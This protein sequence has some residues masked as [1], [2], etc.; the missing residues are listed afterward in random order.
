M[1]C[2]QQQQHTFVDIINGEKQRRK[3]SVDKTFWGDYLE[4]GKFEGKSAIKKILGKHN[5]ENIVFAD[6]VLKINKR[7]KMQQR[8]LICTENAL[9]NIDPSNYKLKRRIPYKSLGM[10]SLSQ[11]P[12]NFFLFHVPDEYDYLM[13]SGKKVEIVTRVSAEYEKV[14]GK[15]L[16]IQF[17][18]CFSYRIDNETTRQIQFTRVDGGVTTQIYT[19][20]DKK[21]KKSKK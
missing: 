15:P 12:D 5:D 13:V 17:E 7:N 20:K 1:A 4:A 11:L 14:M 18:S 19:E 16:K 8:I 2:Q 6:I 10:V 21:D 9:Y 3:S